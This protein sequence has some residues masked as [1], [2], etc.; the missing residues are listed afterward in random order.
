M[1]YIRKTLFILFTSLLL[2]FTAKHSFAQFPG[3]SKVYSN[4]AMQNGNQQMNMMMRT[5][6]MRGVVATQQEYDFE[7]TMLDSTRKQIT[8]AIF[9]DTIARSRFIVWV[10]KSY[11]KSD[12]NRYKRIYP[13]QTKNLTCVLIP[14]DEDNQDQG[15]YLYGKI[16][17][18]CWMFKGIAGP[19]NAYYNSVPDDASSIIVGIQLNNG[20]ILQFSEANLKSM[21]GQNIKVL[22]LISSKKYAKAIKRYNK[23][24]EKEAGK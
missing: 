19:I 13:F 12:P 8:S 6:N 22:D 24:A 20:P 1:L 4:M 2:L 15:K 16:T 23:D 3:M 18:S 21:V 7:V 5:M 10:D 14:K 9:N 11:Q 17:D